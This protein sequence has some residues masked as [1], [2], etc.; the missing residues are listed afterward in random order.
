MQVIILIRAKRH[1]FASTVSRNIKRSG[2]KTISLTSVIG[3]RGDL[4][5]L[6]L[7]TLG[8]LSV[9][10]LVGVTPVESASFPPVLATRDDLGVLGEV[11]CR[12]SEDP[13]LQS[14]NLST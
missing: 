3:L 8:L 5:S 10:V 12:A 13:F 6:T 7:I 4:R 11:L 9:G 1:F 2:C 14:S